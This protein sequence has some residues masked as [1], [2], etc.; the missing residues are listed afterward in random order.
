LETGCRPF[1]REVGNEAAQFL[2]G[3][4]IRLGGFLFR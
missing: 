1:A 4:R 2:D 3:E